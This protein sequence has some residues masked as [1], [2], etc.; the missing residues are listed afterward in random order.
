M[1]DLVAQS[2]IL[3]LLRAS[4]SQIANRDAITLCVSEVLK[5]SRVFKKNTEK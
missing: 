3:R 5:E 4:L 1:V 2:P